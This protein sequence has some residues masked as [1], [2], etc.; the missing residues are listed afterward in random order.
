MTQERPKNIPEENV[1]N[2][3]HWT[4]YL[5]IIATAAALYLII[6]AG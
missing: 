4:I 6:N 1:Y 3:L 2:K 5:V